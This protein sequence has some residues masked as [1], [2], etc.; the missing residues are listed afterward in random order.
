MN[1]FNFY[2][3]EIAFFALYTKNYNCYS[4]HLR[5]VVAPRPEVDGTGLPVERV[6]NDVDVTA[7]SD[8]YF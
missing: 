5:A 8:D 3:I 1:I 2:T 4:T 6:V 7:R